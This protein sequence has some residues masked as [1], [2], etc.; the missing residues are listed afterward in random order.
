MAQLFNKVMA[1]IGKDD[2]RKIGTAFTHQ[3]P[4][5]VLP[6]CEILQDEL[7]KA[8]GLSPEDLHY[9][10]VRVHATKIAHR[11]IYR[12]QDFTL[13]NRA[14]FQVESIADVPA[15]LLV[16]VVYGE[17]GKC[18]SD[19]GVKEARAKLKEL[20]DAAGEEIETP[21]PQAIDLDSIKTDI[22][23]AVVSGLGEIKNLFGGF[24]D[25]VKGALKELIEDEAPSESVEVVEVVETKAEGDTEV[26]VETGDG[27]AAKA[28]DE[29]E[30][31]VVAEEA[32]SKGDKG[33]S[34]NIDANV[35][36]LDGV[37]DEEAIPPADEATVA[38]VQKAVGPKVKVA[39]SEVKTATE[40]VKTVETA[41]VPD[42]ADDNG[43]PKKGGKKSKGKKAQKKNANAQES[44][45]T[46]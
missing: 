42:P 31:T 26:E 34:P 28:T 33:N 16:G 3:N 20:A 24:G 11:Y 19:E 5:M 6:S 1:D 13:V 2:L 22:K 23:S 18:V 8:K 10:L 12:R 43:I 40:E 45:A 30:E 41:P 44:T 46:A 21:V 37:N 9:L 35:V 27:E 36:E 29:E 25:V 39:T 38:K 4:L 15:K 17:L 32:E 7:K 14:L